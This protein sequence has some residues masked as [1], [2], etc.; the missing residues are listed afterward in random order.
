MQC[1]IKSKNLEIELRAK[2]GEAEFDKCELIKSLE[3]LKKD[4]EVSENDKTVLKDQLEITEKSFNEISLDLAEVSKHKKELTQENEVKEAEIDNLK[5]KLT[6]TEKNLE[7][8]ETE[9]DELKSST[10]SQSSVINMLQ[11][12]HKELENDLKEME[13][14]KTGLEGANAALEEEVLQ[15]ENNL[16]EVKKSLEDVESAKE[17]LVED[18]YEL[19]IT[20]QEVEESLLDTQGLVEDMEIKMMEAHN[21]HKEEATELSD[22]LRKV[23]LALDNVKDERTSLLEMN[24]SLSTQVAEALHTI[25]NLQVREDSLGQELGLVKQFMEAAQ[26]ECEEDRMRMMQAEDE[27]ISLQAEME[28]AFI[29][30]EQA[31]DKVQNIGAEA[32]RYR[33]HINQLMSEIGGVKEDHKAELTTLKTAYNSAVTELSE[34]KNVGRQLLDRMAGLE[35]EL[36]A[37][38]KDNSK[39]LRDFEER[40]EEALNEMDK[41]VDTFEQEKSLFADKITHLESLRDNLE[42]TLSKKTELLSTQKNIIEESKQQMEFS[43]NKIEEFTKT[44]LRL[45]GNLDL[46]A[47]ENLKLKEQIEKIK[48]EAEDHQARTEADQAKMKELTEQKADIDR[49]R[50]AEL[51]MCIKLRDKLAK[52]EKEA[53]AGESAV[54]SM[55]AQQVVVMEAEAKLEEEK[56]KGEELLA[57]VRKY[58]ERLDEMESLMSQMDQ[59]NEELEEKAALAADQ[60]KA[61]QDMVEPFKEQL[62]GYEVEKN[63]LLSS[64]E[65]SKDE[66]ALFYGLS[67]IVQ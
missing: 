17:K 61:L 54:R 34:S 22:N 43:I 26:A 25:H 8:V 4:L 66:V 27:I 57:V 12:D 23:T 53:D 35:D 49:L 28:D 48:K 44:N 33:A 37:K 18:V 52:A 38:K 46:R 51:E 65:A 9:R 29:R 36:E 59:R 50:T 10:E 67:R 47:K 58:K 32:E 55:E 63:A 5:T 45:K 13:M 30:A 56:F 19:K 41:M 1:K 2:L 31:E 40:N 14:S 20:K 11:R 15:L 7:K 62:E 24:T 64:Q 42:K 60:L 39:I 3:D 6:D 16:N 21:K